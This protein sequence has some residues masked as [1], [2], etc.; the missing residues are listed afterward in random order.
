MVFALGFSMLSGFE[1]SVREKNNSEVLS[2]ALID[3]GVNTKMRVFQD[4][5]ITQNS[6]IPSGEHGSMVLSLILGKVGNLAP[7][8][9]DRV[10]VFSIDVGSEPTANRL[11]HAI[12]SAVQNKAKVINISMGIRRDSQQ[13]KQA[14]EK[15]KASK[16]LII[17]AAGNVRF[18]SP[19]YPARYPSVISISAID[20]RGEKW[21]YSPS[22]GVDGYNLGDNVLVLDGLG[23][24]QYVSGTSFAAA[25]VTHEVLTKYL[26]GD[27]ANL[28]EFRPTLT[29]LP[30]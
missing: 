13:L 19:D 8:S 23:R 3:T 15:A 26:S 6:N 20:A 11:A 29:S 24:H 9:V 12:N 22:N 17:A 14:V 2:I 30:N 10:K 18:L 25:L 5:S 16:V 28:V 21:G 4:Y 7:V 27:I 1:S